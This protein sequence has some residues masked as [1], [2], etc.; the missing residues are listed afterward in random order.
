MEIN[1]VCLQGDKQCQIPGEPWGVQGSSRTGAEF[2]SW[3]A[4]SFLWTSKKYDAGMQISQ[5]NLLTP[6][7]WIV[8]HKCVNWIASHFMLCE[9]LQILMFVKHLWNKYGWKTT[10][11]LCNAGCSYSR[12]LHVKAGK[13]GEGGPLSDLPC[14]MPVETSSFVMLTA[15]WMDLEALEHGYLWNREP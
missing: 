13:P 4:A 12:L 11:E 3:F 2:P 15:W 5:C 8:V 10:I 7:C 14:A 1:E 9:C 6:S